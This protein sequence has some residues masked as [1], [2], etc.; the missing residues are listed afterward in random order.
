MGK[1]KD[2]IKSER[3]D[4]GNVFIG[5]LAFELKKLALGDIKKG[6]LDPTKPY[7]LKPNADRLIRA[8]RG[9]PLTG[10]VLMSLGTTDVELTQMMKG[11]LT[12]VGFTE[13]IET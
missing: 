8:W 4:V 9:N 5:S 3:K 2:Y 10:G 12:E 11:V 1:V 6:K 7:D 13:I